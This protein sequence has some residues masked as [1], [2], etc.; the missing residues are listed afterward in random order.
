MLLP[1]DV[2]FVKTGGE[3][4]K[5][6]L[7]RFF[8]VLLFPGFRFWLTLVSSAAV[9]WR[10]SNWKALR[11]SVGTKV[12]KIRSECAGSPGVFSEDLYRYPRGIDDSH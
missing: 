12:G 6:S 9:G 8:S 11:L 4:G 1:L 3:V 10:T 2:D 5:N 7:R